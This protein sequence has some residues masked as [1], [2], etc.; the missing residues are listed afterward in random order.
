ML[1]IWSYLDLALLALIMIKS[2]DLRNYPVI[3]QTPTKFIVP[4]EVFGTQHIKE[5][6]LY[7]S[8]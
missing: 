6:V 1:D 3:C 7:L 2:Q 4:Y 8:L 5:A